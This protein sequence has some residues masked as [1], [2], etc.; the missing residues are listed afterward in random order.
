[1]NV[2]AKQQLKRLASFFGITP[3]AMIEIIFERSEQEVM[4]QVGCHLL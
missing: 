4:R 1:M 2:N 3:R